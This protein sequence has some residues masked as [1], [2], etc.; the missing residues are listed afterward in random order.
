MKFIHS[1][2][3]PSEAVGPDSCEIVLGFVKT[4]REEDCDSGECW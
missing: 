4:V 2:E 3:S 1:M